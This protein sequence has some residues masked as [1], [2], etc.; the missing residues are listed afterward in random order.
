[1]AE[2]F[3][4]FFN[5]TMIGQIGDHLA[6]VDPDFD[7]TA[8][9]AIACAGLEPLELKARS[10]HI[11]QAL[12]KTLPDNFRE[13]CELII[14]ALHP[15]DDSPIGDMAMDDQGIRGWPIM[16][17]ADYVAENGMQEFDYSLDVLG[18][19]TRR[20]SAEFAIRHFFLKDWQRTLDKAFAWSKHDN[21]HLRRLAS[22]GSRPLLPWGLKLTG[23]VDDPSPLLPLLEGLKNDPD[24]YVRR[25]VANNLNDIAK[26]H[27]D[28]VATLAKSW[29]VDADRDTQRLVRHAC[30]TL[31]KQ[32]HPPTL[33]ALGYGSPKVKIEKFALK[34]AQVK[35]GQSIEFE[36]EIT[37]S[38]NK[39][40]PL[41]IDYIVHHQRANGTTSP[42]VFKWKTL[43]L[44]ASKIIKLSKKHSMKPVTTRVYYPGTHTL[45]LQINGE[46]MAS[47]NFELSL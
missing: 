11:R 4:N 28:T 41:I 21:V 25:S 17:I 35:T 24:E 38:S 44:A 10:N 43:D 26:H 42:K 18:H 6:R 45:D 15:V 32:G 22:E 36:C 5:A 20:F 19:L 16:P 1:M 47:T 7:N 2:P 29:L 12:E 39:E 34:N 8:F 40:Q 3:K 9:S 46:V 27:P 13:S 23:F 30:R 14:A 37:S 33:A 31:I